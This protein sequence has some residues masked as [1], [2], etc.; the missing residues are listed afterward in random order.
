MINHNWRPCAEVHVWLALVRHFGVSRTALRSEHLSVKGMGTC[1]VE[2][3]LIY[4]DRFFLSSVVWVSFG[5]GVKWI[6]RSS[7][8]PTMQTDPYSCERALS[9]EIQRHYFC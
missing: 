7:L 4:L 6:Y 1:V 2:Q 3:D 8:S 9:E 5:V